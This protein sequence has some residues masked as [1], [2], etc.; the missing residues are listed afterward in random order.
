[1]RV[2]PS[3]ESPVG[4][5][6]PSVELRKHIHTSNTKWTPQIVTI[7]L[8]IYF[9]IAV[10]HKEKEAMNLGGTGGRIGLIKGWKE[11]RNRS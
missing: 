10:I 3:D 9:H 4:F 1:M 7:Y 11:E 2:F 8:I 5:L 6:V